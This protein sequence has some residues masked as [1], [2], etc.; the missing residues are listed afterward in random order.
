ML[1]RRQQA[2]ACGRLVFSMKLHKSVNMYFSTV[3]L[4]LLYDHLPTLPYFRA[5]ESHSVLL[6][7]LL[8]SFATCSLA[9]GITDVNKAFHKIHPSIHLISTPAAIMIQHISTPLGKGKQESLANAEVSARQ[10]CWFK[11]IQ[12]HRFWYQWKAHIRLSISH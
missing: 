6:M 9:Y 8:V 12:G 3:T 1:L 5:K 4:P 2:V 7:S 11:V 10:P